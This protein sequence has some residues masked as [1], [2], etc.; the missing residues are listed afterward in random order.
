[1]K[2][3]VY[4]LLAGAVLW[5]VLLFMWADGQVRMEEACRAAGGEPYHHNGSGDYLGCEDPDT[6]KEI[7]I[8]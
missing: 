3:L 8:P 2:S 1:M 6:F 4:A 5:L 7:E